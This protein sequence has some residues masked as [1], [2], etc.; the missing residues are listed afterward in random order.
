MKVGLV[1]LAAQYA[2]AHEDEVL[3]AREDNH[4][5]CI[6]QHTLYAYVED[7]NSVYKEH[8]EK[9][10]HNSCSSWGRLLVSFGS[11]KISVQRQCIVRDHVFGY[12]NR[13]LRPDV[14]VRLHPAPSYHILR[15]T[16]YKSVLQNW[17]TC[18][19]LTQL[20]TFAPCS[21]FPSRSLS[22]AVVFISK[23]Y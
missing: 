12:G 22:H 16:S 14:L 8:E 1:M 10:G 23:Y 15:A 17:L 21:L 6:G 3:L 5:T 18:L 9:F 11:L 20:P 13:F 7:R 2:M 4:D 19:I